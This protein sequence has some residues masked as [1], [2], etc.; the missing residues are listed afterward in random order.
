MSLVPL[1]IFLLLFCSVHSLLRNVCVPH[2]SFLE[3]TRKEPNSQIYDVPLHQSGVSPQ[4]RSAGLTNFPSRDLHPSIVVSGR[5]EN[6]PYRN[7]NP[8]QI[9]LEPSHPASLSS[10]CTPFSLVGTT[11][12]RAQTPANA[13]VFPFFPS[14]K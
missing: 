14:K 3:P 6:F 9:G 11:D 1:K 8:R 7:C 4:T 12:Q 2:F 5:N 10:G 13:D